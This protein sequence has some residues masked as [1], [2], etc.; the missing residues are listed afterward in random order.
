[1]FMGT[2]NKRQVVIDNTKWSTLNCAS[3]CCPCET[4]CACPCGQAAPAQTKE[5]QVEEKK[6][7][8]EEKK[9]T[10]EVVKKSS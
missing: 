10:E 5:E 8:K 6:E 3:Q 2:V 9:K 7:K 1:M 4:C